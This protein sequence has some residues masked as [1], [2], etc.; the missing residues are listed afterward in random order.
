MRFQ[1]CTPGWPDFETALLA[2]NVNYEMHMYPDTLHG[3][4]NNSTPRFNP[5]AATLAWERTIE[6]FREHL[7][8]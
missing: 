6:F 4:H 7:S 1:R 3:F 8:D 5:E 2:N